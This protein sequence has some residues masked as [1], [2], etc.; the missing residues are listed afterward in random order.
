[1][2]AFFPDNLPNLVAV[3]P[4]QLTLAA[5]NG[6]QPTTVTIGGQQYRVPSQ[7]VLNT[8]TVGANGL[9]AGSLGAVQLWYVYAI[10][11]QSTFAVALVASQNGPSVGP[12]SPA[13]Y[14]TAE[15]LVGA[16]YTNGS[17]QVGSVVALTGKVSTGFMSWTPLLMSG[18]GARGTG[19][20]EKAWWRRSGESLEV[21]WSYSQT[22]A[23]TAGN[24][25]YGWSLPGSLLIDSTKIPAT[26]QQ[27]GLGSC[28]VFSTA[29][30]EKSGQVMFL[31]N[32]VDRFAL[33]I[34][35]ITNPWNG[36]L[37]VQR[38]SYFSLGDADLIF[39]VQFSVPISGWTN[40]LL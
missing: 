38:S 39:T 11:N 2:Q 35:N 3:P 20:N 1:M 7:L 40:T 22:G 8:G 12:T 24:N 36:G 28:Y 23:G 18:L 19:V 26:S 17:S 4:T 14:G 21:D 10:I 25:I 32:A 27:R 34:P 13:G 33:E 30:G 6:V 29:S 9:D 5:T 15:K 37:N 31:N 16:F